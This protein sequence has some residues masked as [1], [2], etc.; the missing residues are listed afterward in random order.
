[1]R[2]T[3]KGDYATRA[4]QDLA[5]HYGSGPI[6]I[7]KIAVRQGLPVRYLEQLL[8]TLR[9][10]GILQSKRGVNGGYTLAKPPAET[11]LGAILRAVDGPVEPISCLAEAPR[12]PCA[13]EAVCALRDVWSDV[14]RAVA[15]IV[16]RTTLQDVCDRSRAAAAGPDDHQIFPPTDSVA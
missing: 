5:L 3:T 10:A 2:I 12:E 4:L 6:P 9:R 13:R 14:H 7:D 8:L 15:A 1:M 16:D 11:T